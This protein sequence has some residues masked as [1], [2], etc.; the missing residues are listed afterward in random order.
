MAGPKSNCPLGEVIMLNNF[1]AY[2]IRAARF[3]IHSH[4]RAICKLMAQLMLYRNKNE[5]IVLFVGSHRQSLTANRH[6]IHCVLI[7]IIK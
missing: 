3:A 4:V 1:L 2:I 5:W 7:K 6:T